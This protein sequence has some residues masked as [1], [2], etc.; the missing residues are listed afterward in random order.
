MKEDKSWSEDELRDLILFT[1]SLR[2]ENQEL[3]SKIIVMDTL[4]NKREA[5]LRRKNMYIRH[6][7][8]TIAESGFGTINLN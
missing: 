8:E 3:Q 6:L 1:Q 7:E 2:E 5:E 4:L